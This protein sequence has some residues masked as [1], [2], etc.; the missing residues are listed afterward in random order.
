MGGVK[1]QITLKF[2]FWVH[3]RKGSHEQPL[4][5]IKGCEFASALLQMALQLQATH[6]THY[7]VQLGDEPI[8]LGGRR[9]HF[10]SSTL[11]SM[12]RWSSQMQLQC[13]LH[14]H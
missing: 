10:V 6:A 7:V 2:N 12:L 4:L 14:I 3:V 1:G 8:T 11:V 13:E 9:E 5:G